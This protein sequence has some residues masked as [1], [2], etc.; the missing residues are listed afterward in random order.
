MNGLAERLR[1]VQEP[2]ALE[3]LDQLAKDK[4]PLQAT[5]LALQG[6]SGSLKDNAITA[7]AQLST[8]YLWSMQPDVRAA[9][10]ELWSKAA[11]SGPLAVDGDG[12]GK[13]LASADPSV[14]LAR[15]KSLSNDG[16]SSD[17][18]WLAVQLGAITDAGHL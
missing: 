14:A 8:R 16:S 10:I 9:Y 11:K 17:A 3:L 1:Y 15:L 18:R 5:R 2:L 6:G 4:T 12:L 13:I 7:V